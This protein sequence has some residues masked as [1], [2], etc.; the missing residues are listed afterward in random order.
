MQTIA[1]YD[2]WILSTSWGELKIWS[3][4]TY[5]LLNTVRIFDRVVSDIVLAD[6]KIICCGRDATE[7][8]DSCGLDAGF[9]TWELSLKGG[10][11]SQTDIVKFGGPLRAAIGLIALDDNRV[12]TC[13]LRGVSWNVEIW[14]V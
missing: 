3:S 8:G 11:E 9:K 1:P 12:A 13:V 5:E 14:Q 4:T 6:G 10:K 7:E 2:D